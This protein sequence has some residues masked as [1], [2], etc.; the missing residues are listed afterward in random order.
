MV[1]SIA[2]VI[3]KNQHRFERKYKVQYFDFGCTP[4]AYECIEE[5]NKTVFNYLDSKYGGKWRREVR[6]N[7][8]F[9]EEEK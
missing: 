3:Y 4:P 8:M 2:P 6:P 7:V 5:C 9:L 1:G